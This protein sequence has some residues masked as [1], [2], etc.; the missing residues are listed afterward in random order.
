MWYNKDNH[1]VIGN[2]YFYRK[3]EASELPNK[4]KI[5]IPRSKV[6]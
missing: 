4:D 5:I 1:L 6:I 3:P 2:N